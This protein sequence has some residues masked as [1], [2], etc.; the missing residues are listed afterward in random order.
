[1]RM[2]ITVHG[3]P[4]G[5]GGG[6]GG[7]RVG[8]RPPSWKIP[9]FFLLY[10]GPFCCV[11]LL[12]EG[13]FLL[14][15]GLFHYVRGLFY[16]VGAIFTTWEPFSYFFLHM[17]GL[18]VLMGAFFVLMGAFFVLMG[19]LIFVL[20]GAFFGLAPLQKILRAPML[21]LS[22]II[23]LI[24]SCTV[25]CMCPTLSANIAMPVSQCG[26]FITADFYSIF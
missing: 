9:N 15:E 20:M 11:F 5:G 24:I 17:G 8:G 6:V 13:L 18:F 23:T 25:S 19:A 10:G 3:R 2:M 12:M 26:A 1:M 14:M 22:P 16:N 7:C 4:Q 21:L